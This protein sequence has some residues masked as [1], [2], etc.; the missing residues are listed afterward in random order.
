MASTFV[1]IGSRYEAGHS[2]NPIP[3][4]DPFESEAW[5][6]ASRFVHDIQMS[7]LSPVILGLETATTDVGATVDPTQT[8][9]EA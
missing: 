7:G 6:E 1:D 9:S 3:E 8:Y 4:V 2:G 5:A